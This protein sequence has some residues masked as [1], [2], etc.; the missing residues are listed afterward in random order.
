MALPPHK[1]DEVFKNTSDP[2]SA[3]LKSPHVEAAFAAAAAAYN[4][5]DSD[6]ADNPGLVGPTPWQAARVAFLEALNG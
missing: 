1:L 4:K 6:I 3:F 2:E 5:T